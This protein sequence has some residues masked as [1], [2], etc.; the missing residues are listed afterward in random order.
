MK[1]NKLELEITVRIPLLNTFNIK[2]ILDEIDL[3]CFFDTSD[4]IGITRI[5][6]KNKGIAYNDENNE[7][8]KSI[9][10]SLESRIISKKIIKT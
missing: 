9:F 3:D 6:D 7:K 2:K 4:Y 8:Y 5:K 1:I 10:N